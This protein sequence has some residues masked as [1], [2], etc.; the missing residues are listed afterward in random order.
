MKVVIIEDELYSQEKLI[1]LLS[2]MDQSIEVAAALGS[3]ADSVDWFLNHDM[4]DLIFVDIELSDGTC[5]EIFKKVPTNCPVV[6]VTAYDNYAIKAFRVNSLD[7]ILKPIQKEDIAGCIIKY[8]NA[9]RPE[10]RQ[11]QHRIDETDYFMR[12]KY[13]SRFISKRG[14]TYNFVPIEDVA[15]FTLE[16]AGTVLHTWEGKKHYIE[17]NMDTLED[18]LNPGAFF[19][20][21]RTFI[22]NINAID[23]VVKFSNRRLKVMIRDYPREDII[24][25]REK[26]SDFKAWLDQ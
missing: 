15:F 19:R 2:E 23:Q 25:S 5:F 3:V 10:P 1:T 17:Y 24:M 18:V 4:P 12:H 7:Y 8:Y 16:K 22:A 20:I 11:L 26:V 14:D 6:F 21:N 13:K 9:V